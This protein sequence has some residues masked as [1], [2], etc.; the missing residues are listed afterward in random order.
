MNG[1]DALITEELGRVRYEEGE[2]RQATAWMTSKARQGSQGFR[3]PMSVQGSGAV[4]MVRF[5]LGNDD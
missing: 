4:P 1:L 5:L 3:V 2:R